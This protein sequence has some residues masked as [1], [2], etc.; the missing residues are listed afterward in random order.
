[1]KPS[2]DNNQ[3]NGPIVTEPIVTAPI[4]QNAA[5]TINKPNKKLLYFS[6]FVALVASIAAGIFAYLY[7][8]NLGPEEPKPE[9]A[10]SD[11]QDRQD[12]TPNSAPDTATSEST[13]SD[14]STIANLDK[15]MNILHRVNNSNIQGKSIVIAL[16]LGY[17]IPLY[18]K[19][20]L[21]DNVRLTHLIDSLYDWNATGFTGGDFRT[22]SETEMRT[23]RGENP[24]GIPEY[25]NT[26]VDADIVAAKYKD[27]YGTDIVHGSL[28]NNDNHYCPH[29]FYSEKLHLYYVD[30]AGCGGKWDSVRQYYK[31]NYTKDN[32]HAYVYVA[33]GT[34][35]F[36]D[37]TDTTEYIFCNVT[38]DVF[39]NKETCGKVPENYKRKDPFIDASNY[40]KFAKYRFVF[41]KAT[42]G[43]YYFSKVEKI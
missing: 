35:G 33:A 18:E 24:N 39:E 29:Y 21:N 6:I 34:I 2:I 8:S 37:E 7:F 26:G 10:P 28:N 38:N 9:T 22:L 43:S 17:E 3:S 23:L 31:Y 20:N 15:K 11:V 32:E 16:S 27:L 40:Q 19:G 4:E 13:I 5:P 14:E 25:T 42:N 30:S 36:L 1:M 12:D 41:N